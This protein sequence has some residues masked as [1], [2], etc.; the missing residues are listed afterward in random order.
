VRLGLRGAA[1]I[2]IAACL[3]AACDASRPQPPSYPTL[4]PVA[5]RTEPWDPQTDAC[6]DVGLT[7]IL[8]GSAADP[9]VAWL[10]DMGGN[11][12]RLEVFWPADLHAVF[13]P[14]LE[15]V[16]P[17][18]NAVTGEGDFIDGGCV[19]GPD[20][21]QLL[22]AP[23]YPGFRLD[24]SL[25]QPAECGARASRIASARGSSAPPIALI[26][27]LDGS[28]RYNVVYRDGTQAQ[29]LEPGN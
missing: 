28:G 20:G 8:H 19:V 1:A 27:F 23:P 24:C 2:A 6:R 9:S 13:D 3:V 12:Q 26:R 7:A 16:D 29:G 18:G 4:T 15:I 17:G 14:G 22:L 10:V 21:S 5:L 11:H 25:M